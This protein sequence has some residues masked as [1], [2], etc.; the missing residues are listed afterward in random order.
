MHHLPC[1]AAALTL[2]LSACA[3]PSHDAS[4]ARACAADCIND[5]RQPAASHRAPLGSEAI[6]Q[7]SPNQLGIVVPSN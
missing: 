5:K 1:A 3:T 4:P 7:R 6:L 2:A